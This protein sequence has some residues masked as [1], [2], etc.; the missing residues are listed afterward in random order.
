[1]FIERFR[2][3]VNWL[4]NE[5]FSRNSIESVY[6]SVSENNKYD[7]SVNFEKRTKGFKHILARVKLDKGSVLDLACGT[8]AI[9][10]ALKDRNMHILGVDNSSGMLQIAQ[11]KLKKWKNI[12]FKKG[13]FMTID[14]PNN[15]FDLITIAHA[16]RFVP[17]D[18]EEK[19]TQKIYRLLKQDG[20]FVIIVHDDNFFVR[21]YYTLLSLLGANKKLNVSFQLK[22]I[23]IEK[24]KPF[25]ILQEVV[26]AHDSSFD[27]KDIGI[28]FK[29]RPL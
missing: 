25:F 13:N 6:D 8:G 12:S 15:R 14:L 20:Y 5:F 27:Y 29:K 9:E 7:T 17:Q 28:I 26:P 23:L 1:M 18:S 2:F 10:V 19:F 21:S 24:L 16:I 3:V 11:K 4:T 22:D